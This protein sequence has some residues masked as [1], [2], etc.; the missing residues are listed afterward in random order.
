MLF[1]H[2][3]SH[4]LLCSGYKASHRVTISKKLQYKT[5]THIHKTCAH[6]HACAHKRE[7]MQGVIITN[8][9]T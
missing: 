4:P 5:H 9:V 2:N 7:T 6:T 1:L 8:M 3:L